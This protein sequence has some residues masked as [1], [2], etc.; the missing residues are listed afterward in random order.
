MIEDMNAL[1]EQLKLHEGLR[2]KPY[3]CTAGKLTIGIGRNLDDRGISEAEAMFLLQNDLQECIA[4]AE[5]I[6]GSQ[7]WGGL[8]EARKR[9]LVDMRFNLGGRGLRSFKNT[10]QAVREG[11]YADASRGMLNSKWAGQVG[12]RAKTLAQMMLEG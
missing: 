7:V 10:L 4:D 6:I 2:L 9:C 12:R 3:R 5:A 11:R 1:C 8:S